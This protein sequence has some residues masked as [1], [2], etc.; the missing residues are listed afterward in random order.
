[1]CYPHIS[2]TSVDLSATVGPR[3]LP[4]GTDNLPV[5]LQLGLGSCFTPPFT[6][7]TISN[8]RADCFKKI[9][10]IPGSDPLPSDEGPLSSIGDPS[11]SSCSLARPFMNYQ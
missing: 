2:A 3:L 4:Y 9:P 1:V 7:V 8:S 6:A 5:K 10:C 11:S